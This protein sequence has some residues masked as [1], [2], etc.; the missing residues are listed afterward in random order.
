MNILL[1]FRQKYYRY[2][3]LILF[4]ICSVTSSKLVFAQDA[5]CAEVKIVIEQKLSFERQAF[6]ARMIINNG[7]ED[8]ILK[9]IRIE[10]L[11]TDRNNQQVVT[12]QN[13]N[14]NDA[15]F[16]YRINSL[17]GVNSIN[18]DGE[19]KAKTK[20]EAHWLIIPAYGAAE[21]DNT[22]YYIGAKV[23]YTLNGQEISVE[24]PPDYVVIKPQPLLT[25][26]YFIPSEVYGDDPFTPEIEPS[27]PFTLGV[28]V[29]NEGHGTSYKTVIDSAQPKIVENKQNLLIDFSIL[30][31]YLGDHAVNK[32]LLLDFGDIAGHTSKVG[33]WDMMT[34]LHGK[35]VEFDATFTHAD[36]LGGSV[37]SLLKTVNTH[38]L[39]HNVRVDLPDRDNITDFLALDGDVI[40]VYESEGFNTDLSDQSLNATLTTVGKETKLVFPKTEGQV[41]VKIADPSLG[42]QKMNRVIRS[43]GKVLPAENIWQS[44]IR[45]DDLSWS[46][47]I[48]LFD[49]NSTGSYT[50][51]ESDTNETKAIVGT[52]LVT[53][54]AKY[55][56]NELLPENYY[57][58]ANKS[59][60]IEFIG[61]IA[62]RICAGKNNFD[63]NTK[64]CKT[65]LNRNY[66]FNKDAFKTDIFI[67]SKSGILHGDS[68]VTGSIYLLAKQTETI[69]VIVVPLDME[70]SL[71]NTTSV[72]KGFRYSLNELLP[73]NYN[74]QADKPYLVKFSGVAMTSRYCP[75]KANFDLE[76]KV[77]KA[78]VSRDY[79]FKSDI[80]IPFKSGI[81]G[82]NNEFTGN[83]YMSA[84]K[85]GDIK[86]YVTPL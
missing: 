82:K 71:T 2:F 67:P 1:K 25:L 11:F 54:G 70:N 24:V 6:D 65:G 15:K 41:Y 27:I 63:Q 49:T 56:L 50:L 48:N 83:F 37:T 14:D 76:S 36:T 68:H 74:F 9:N 46:Y 79:S 12:T 16:F 55:S 72:I 34:S 7:L 80:F 43:D 19:I 52:F 35:F 13:A 4:F 45:N 39:I 61:N 21:S 64:K 75:G 30:G 62:S 8:S 86:V 33:R 57:F 5:I 66:T 69:K 47:Y 22:L 31:S 60:M 42:N 81:L 32:S 84:T 20:A 78:G 73:K 17:S 53:K 3:M 59:Y 26:D 58:E 18:G 40:R 44:K 29:K 51:Y 23:T 10:L 38:T 77:C 85:D 28:R